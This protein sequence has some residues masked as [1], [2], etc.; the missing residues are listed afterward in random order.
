MYSYPPWTR[1]A[2][3]IQPKREKT[4]RGAASRRRGTQLLA[5]R[6]FLFSSF[7]EDRNK[8]D[9][10]AALAKPACIPASRIVVICN[11][12]EKNTSWQQLVTVIEQLRARLHGLKLDA[13]F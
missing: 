8:N 3:V 12:L 2:Q 13:K 1:G 6:S 11:P 9:L 5:S 10:P 4:G 7:Q